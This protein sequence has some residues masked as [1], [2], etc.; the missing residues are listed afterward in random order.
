M[1]AIAFKSVVRCAAV[2]VTVR[3]AVPFVQESP[4]MVRWVELPFLIASVYE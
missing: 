2:S 3:V 1:D 4:E